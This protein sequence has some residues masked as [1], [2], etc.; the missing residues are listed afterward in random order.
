MKIAKASPQ[1]S[2][3]LEGAE[4]CRKVLLRQSLC[5]FLHQWSSPHPPG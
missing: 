3:F 4:I 5:L 1:A 2:A